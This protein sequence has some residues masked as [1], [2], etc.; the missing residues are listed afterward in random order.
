MQS[1]LQE[2]VSM[3][4]RERER[5][6]AFSCRAKLF[7]AWMAGKIRYHKVLAIIGRWLS[8]HLVKDGSILWPTWARYLQ[9][10]II[11]CLPPRLP[12]V[13][14]SSNE[15]IPKY[16]NNLLTLFNTIRMFMPAIILHLD[17]KPKIW[18]FYLRWADKAVGFLGTSLTSTLW[19]VM[20]PPPFL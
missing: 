2:C 6:N 11:V 14:H 20:I 17:S 5:E 4:E 18:G 9:G 10:H 7:H 16:F 12:W 8:T 19:F 13:V 15:W 3:Q 1:R